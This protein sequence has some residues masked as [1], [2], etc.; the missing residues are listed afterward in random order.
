MAGGLENELS[1]AILCMHFQTGHF[2]T[3]SR[4]R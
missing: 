1:P 3:F 4:R 2:M